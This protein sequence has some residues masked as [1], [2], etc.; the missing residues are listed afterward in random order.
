MLVPWLYFYA[1]GM[2]LSVNCD[3]GVLTF[4]RCFTT[5]DKFAKKWLDLL[6]LAL[7]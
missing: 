6:R 3:G 7:T 5:A 1:F 2:L 4:N